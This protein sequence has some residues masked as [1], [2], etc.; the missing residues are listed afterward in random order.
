V[1]DY[2][3]DT[4]IFFHIHGLAANLLAGL[5]ESVLHR[6]PTDFFPGGSA[7]LPEPIN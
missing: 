2:T 3:A 1:F 5:F 6:Q 4:T 7:T